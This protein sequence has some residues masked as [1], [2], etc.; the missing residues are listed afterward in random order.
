VNHCFKNQNSHGV[1]QWS[2]HLTRNRWMFLQAPIKGF[3]CFYK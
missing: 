1:A 3:R 2:A